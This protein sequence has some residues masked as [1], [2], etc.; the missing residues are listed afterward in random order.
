[1]TFSYFL[2]ILNQMTTTIATHSIN[3]TPQRGNYYGFFVATFYLNRFPNA[4][5]HSDY[6]YQNDDDHIPYTNR[7]R[8]QPRH[9]EKFSDN[10][11]EMVSNK[12]VKLS[13]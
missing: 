10:E 8:T 6:G 7:K 3:S 13:T 2:L 4:H 9:R 1:M 5:T 12:A 11:R